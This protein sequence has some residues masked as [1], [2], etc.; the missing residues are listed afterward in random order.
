MHNAKIHCGDV[1]HN[2]GDWFSR[3]SW[4]VKETL[5]TAETT[6]EFFPSST[7]VGSVFNVSRVGGVWKTDP[8]LTAIQ[9][10]KQQNEHML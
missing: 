7:P 9:K 10:A 5:A 2:H 1:K 3:Y 8:F 4:P 6:D